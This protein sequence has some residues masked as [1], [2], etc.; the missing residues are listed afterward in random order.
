[1]WNSLIIPI[2]AGVFYPL[3][4]TLPAAFAGLSEVFSIF[5]VIIL[6]V[7]LKTYRIP[8]TIKRLEVAN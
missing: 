8:K 4:F 2:A 5:P 6:S 3:N 1:L 7:L